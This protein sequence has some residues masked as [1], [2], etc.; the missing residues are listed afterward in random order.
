MP[1]PR[2]NQSG[3]NIKK[4][5]LPGLCRYGKIVGRGGKRIKNGEGSREI[6]KKMSGNFIYQ[7]K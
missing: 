7:W 2:N 3:T 4:K 6:R 1:T 5:M